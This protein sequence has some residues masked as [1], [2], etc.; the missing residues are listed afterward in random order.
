LLKLEP[1]PG[2]D[3]SRAR[4]DL[5]RVATDPD[6]AGWARRARL[7]MAWLDARGGR[8]SSAEAGLVRLVIDSPSSESAMRAEVFL[9][10][11]E[12]YDGAFGPAAA[13][14][15]RVA[16]ELG[17]EIAELSELRELAIAGALREAGT[18]GSWREARPRPRVTTGVRGIA[19][20]SEMPDGGLIVSDRKTGSVVRLDRAG[21]EVDRWKVGAPGAVT[22][23]PFG[24]IWAVSGDSAV[25]LRT[26]GD[27][28]TVAS[29]AKIAPVSGFAVD[30]EGALWISDRKGGRVSR[31]VPGAD[32]P[33]EIWAG[34]DGKI[35]SLAWDRRR[36]VALDSKNG[37][38]LELTSDGHAVSVGDAAFQKAEAMAVD[39]AGQIAV[40]D[41]RDGAVVLFGPDGVERNRVTLAAVGVAKPTAMT[42]AADGSLVLF[43]GTG[44][45]M[46]R[47][48]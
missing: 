22:V 35:T 2:A 41:M 1:L 27:V 43:D 5:A 13:R 40:L 42:L 3:R 24:R 19:G 38:I 30:A 20:V 6:G 9:A 4:L 16:E 48:P 11:L 37:R 47:L 17:V 7:T 12:L 44:G 46:V 45:A 15:D 10:W 26:S 23:D 8:A 36:I 28:D 25:R 14:L 29:L 21:T 39:A 34:D 32:S 31:I 33:Q 18:G